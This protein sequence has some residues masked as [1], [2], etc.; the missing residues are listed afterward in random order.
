MTPSR[1]SLV[2]PLSSPQGVC[3]SSA[4]LCSQGS[5]I[6]LPHQLYSLIVTS[7]DPDKTIQLFRPT[8]HRFEDGNLEFLKLRLRLKDLY[9][10]RHFLTE[11][12]LHQVCCGIICLYTM[13]MYDSH[14]LIKKLTGL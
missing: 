12:K 11:I 9:L 7:L 10:V 8:G 6:Y 5:V 14:W 3:F 1:L 2:Q 4:K 13:N